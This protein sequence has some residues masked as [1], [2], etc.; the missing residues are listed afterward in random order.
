MPAA[1]HQSRTLVRKERLWPGVSAAHAKYQ[2][3]PELT[4]GG[5]RSSWPRGSPVR[6]PAASSW[7]THAATGSIGSTRAAFGGDPL[8]KV[9]KTCELE[10]VVTWPS[11]ADEGAS[12]SF[13]DTRT[14]VPPGSSAQQ[15]RTLRVRRQ[16]SEAIR[17]S[18]CESTA[19]WAR[20][21]PTVPRKRS[22]ECVVGT[23]VD[24]DHHSASNPSCKNRG[25]ELRQLVD[26]FERC[27]HLQLLRGEIA[28]QTSPRHLAQGSRRADRVYAEERDAQ[29][30]RTRA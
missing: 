21:R 14:S 2:S 11:C 16:R 5:D 28:R 27:D 18:M 12:C 17:S 19:S 26:R 9:R 6:T 4:G 1:K 24:V 3:C 8:F 10:P 23:C 25:R 15:P 22:R 7:I 13:S 20:P 29:R 30:L